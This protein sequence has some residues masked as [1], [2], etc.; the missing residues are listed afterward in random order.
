MQLETRPPTLREPLEADAECPSYPTRA[1]TRG[2]RAAMLRCLLAPRV[3]RAP[4]C[5]PTY[6]EQRRAATHPRRA[7][8]T[9]EAN[10]EGLRRAADRLTVGI[11]PLRELLPHGA[12]SSLATEAVSGILEHGDGLR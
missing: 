6:P 2:K 3:A 8:L 10:A 9:F 5:L 12:L 1:A 11:E 4:T 7:N